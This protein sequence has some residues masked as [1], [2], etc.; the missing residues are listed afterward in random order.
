MGG[1]RM[2]GMRFLLEMGAWGVTWYE[3]HLETAVW[4]RT[5]SEC[6]DCRSILSVTGQKERR[7]VWQSRVA[8]RKVLSVP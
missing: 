2:M 5:V 7:I 3:W 4:V 1:S 8:P 6:G